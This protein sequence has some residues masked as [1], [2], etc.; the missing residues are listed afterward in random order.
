MK[1]AIFVIFSIICIVSLFHA[2]IIDALVLFLI[3]GAV[4][5]TSQI[6]SPMSM[7]I[8]LAIACFGGIIVLLKNENQLLIEPQLIKS[9]PVTKKESAAKKAKVKKHYYARLK[10]VILQKTRRFRRQLHRRWAKSLQPKVLTL[11]GQ[12]VAAPKARRAR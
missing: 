8:I 1:K 7:A 5:G 11:R 9:R 4:P 6:L 10:K 3:T 12:I 2:G